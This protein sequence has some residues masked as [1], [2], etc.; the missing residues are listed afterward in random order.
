MKG[1]K[2]TLLVPRFYTTDF[3]EMEQL[4]N[5]EMNKNEA[6]TVNSDPPIAPNQTRTGG[7][8]DKAEPQKTNQTMIGTL[9]SQSV[10]NQTTQTLPKQSSETL[11]N[12]TQ[13]GTNSSS[14]I[15]K[16]IREKANGSA[17]STSD[18]VNKGGTNGTNTGGLAKPGIEDLVK[19]LLNCNMFDGNWVRDES[20]PLYKPGSC[21]L[22]DEQFNCFANGRPDKGF[23]M[24]KW[25]PN[26]C[27][28][29]RGNGVDEDDDI[30]LGRIEGKRLICP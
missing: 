19:N 10:S 6:P 9:P 12:A 20:Y 21:S 24:L 15:P 4:F 5:T 25:K 1:I 8:R 14:G 16:S 3:D 30:G 17:N 22:I 18:F 29:P 2:E 27:T 13:N 11:K 23:Q 28:L 7:V 26:A